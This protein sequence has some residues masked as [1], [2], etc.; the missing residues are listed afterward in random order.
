MSLYHD[1]PLSSLVSETRPSK[2]YCASGSA[3][4]LVTLVNS[5]ASVSAGDKDGLTGKKRLTV[6]SR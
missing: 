6:V 2:T 3:D 5:G 4:A 1:L